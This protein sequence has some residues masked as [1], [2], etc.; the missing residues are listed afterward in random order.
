MDKIFAIIENGRTE[1]KKWMFLFYYLYK[2]IHQTRE[3]GELLN[4][5]KITNYYC[6]YVKASFKDTL[7]GKWINFLI[8]IY[9]IS[10]LG[11]FSGT[12]R[13]VFISI[14]N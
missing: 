7:N 11:I 8:A 10:D 3:Y 9:D 12:V 4:G 6:L 2:Y 1:N 13:T 14:K 5:L